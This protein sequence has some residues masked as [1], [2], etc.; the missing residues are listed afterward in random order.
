MPKLLS[1]AS[2]LS[3]ATLAVTLISGVALADNVTPS[4]D[5]APGAWTTDRYAPNSFNSIGNG[6]IQIGIDPA[7]GAQNRPSGFG[8]TFYNTQ[9]M[10]IGISGGAGDT[11]SANLYVP[12]SWGN[13]TLGA[14]RTDM[15]LV[16]NDPGSS[17]DPHDYPILGFT[18]FPT[19]S[20]SFVGFRAWDTLNGTWDNLSSASIN[21]DGWN[22]LSIT[23][24]D[25][26]GVIHF[27]Y[28][29]NGTQ[30][31]D[32]VGDATDTTYDKVLLQA[33]NFNDTNIPGTPVGG[34]YTADWA[35]PEPASMA[36]L[37][38][39]LAG[40]AAMRRRRAA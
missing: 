20:T 1:F 23:M 37:G 38:F 19:D 33:Y 39:G 8:G 31:A 25:V 4:F 9:G 6:T 30:V 12:S 10:G 22:A 34:A 32:I 18:N 14:V 5:G 2:R 15:W 21:Y 11:L 26:A 16:V 13:P 7:Q 17:P 40:L 24:Q 3:A 28:D 35:V 27:L 36:L 29:V